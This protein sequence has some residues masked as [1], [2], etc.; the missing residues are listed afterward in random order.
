MKTESRWIAIMAFYLVLLLIILLLPLSLTSY[1]YEKQF[2][3]RIKADNE[4]GQRYL[5]EHKEL[6]RRHVTF[7]SNKGQK[8]NGYFYGDP[9][10]GLIVLAHGLWC[11][12][13]DYISEIH[14]FV[15]SGYTVFA[16][17]NTG[18]GKSE[19]RSIIGLAQSQ[20]DLHYALLYLAHKNINV[21]MI[22]YGHSWGGFAVS[23]VL[24][25]SH[26]DIAGVIVRSGFNY[27]VK[28]ISSY[29]NGSYGH[30]IEMMRPWIFC[31]ER[32]KQG[33]AS[34]RKGIDGIL[35]SKA[36]ILIYHGTKDTMVPLKASLYWQAHNQ[37]ADNKRIQT[38]MLEGK[39]H[40]LI[41]TEEALSYRT[42][43][44][45]K[46]VSSI[47]LE[48]YFQMDEDIINE[49]LEFFQMVLN[50]HDIFR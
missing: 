45:D 20:V 40:N 43:C 49:M 8:I 35:N 46:S 1:L 39:G 34:G 30:W 14:E 31:Y 15:K 37:S 32:L 2:G 22:L 12:H 29:G 3:I 42:R 50:K 23:S 9:G 24:T 33:D 5:K 25:Y 16:Y 21:P 19:G 28:M 10:K 36:D 18:C 38:R 13:L 6:R 26:P 47:D 17:D 48:K 44:K 41:Y 11:N 7:A 27:S 4:I